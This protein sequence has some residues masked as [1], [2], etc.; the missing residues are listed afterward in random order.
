MSFSRKEQWKKEKEKTLCSEIICRL[1][2]RKIILSMAEIGNRR[3][4]LD[5]Y[6]EEKLLTTELSEIKTRLKLV[7][8]IFKNGNA[9]PSAQS[10][11]REQY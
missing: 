6:L 7:Q 1:Q 8:K 5:I 3:R 10:K 9:H 2:N 4:A 11:Q